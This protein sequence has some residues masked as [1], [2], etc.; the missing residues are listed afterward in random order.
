MSEGVG[1]PE[2][3]VLA[4]GVGITISNLG[5]AYRGVAAV[6]G[7]TFG[8]S[9]GACVAIVGA[10][11][12]GK[13]STLNGI[14]GHVRVRRGSS[15]V[16]GGT[17]LTKVPDPAKRAQMG[18]GHVLEDRHVFGGLS[19]TENL[20]LAHRY[21]AGRSGP[22]WG[23]K[24]ALALFPELTLLCNRKAGSLSGGQ[25]QFLAIGRAL[26]GQPRL[27]MLDEPT[28]GLAP[29]L[30]DR[31]IDVI[32]EIGAM[33]L[34]VLLVEQRLE[35]ATSLAGEIHIMSHGQIVRTV[36]ADDPEISEHV[37]SAYLS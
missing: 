32:R 7:V 8:V 9:P 6:S 1:E 2:R 24:L 29:Q 15:V 31:V 27:L 33:G 21:R 14:A 30:V 16:L 37:E 34:T 35:V 36:K 28:N 20:D 26:A 23:R 18:L 4:D 12:A 22:E 19:V 25:Q 5:V 11:G 3:A 17:D 13:T 10:N